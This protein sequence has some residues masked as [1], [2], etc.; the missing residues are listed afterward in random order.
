MKYTY[1]EKLR[2][3]FKAKDQSGVCAMPS[4]IYYSV[5]RFESATVVILYRKKYGS[6]K[7]NVWKIDNNKHTKISI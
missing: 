1:L 5:K 6:L 4:F 7:A 2:S 3:E